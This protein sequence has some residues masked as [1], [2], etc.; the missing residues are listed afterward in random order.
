MSNAATIA[1]RNRTISIVVPAY[2]AAEFI[3]DT[4]DS[5]QR[6]TYRP[7]EIIVVDDGST[8]GTAAFVRD[9]FPDVKLI[10]QRNQGAAAARNAGIAVATGELIG[11]VDADDRWLPDAAARLEAALRQSPESVALA[12]AW[13]TFIDD[14]G[15]PIGSG[16]PSFIAGDV[17]ATL[18]AVNFLG[19]ASATLVRR[20]AFERV[21]LFD[22]SLKTQDA[23]GCDDWDLYLRIAERFQFAV[24]PEYLIEYRKM[25][26]SMTVGNPDSMS[27]S[28]A[29]VLRRM[30][31]RG[32]HMP[33]LVRRMSH[34]IFYTYLAS[35]C[36]RHGRFRESQSCLAKAVWCG[37][38]WIC[39]LPSFYICLANVLLRRKGDS[40]AASSVRT[41]DSVGANRRF[42]AVL[43]RGVHRV[44]SKAC[45]QIPR[46]TVVS[47]P[48]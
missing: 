34:A 16:L 43:L 21:G 26:G 37:M 24:V 5:L 46:Q 23:S 32:I 27:R 11:F 15:R 10:E 41:A 9:N 8:D 30:T 20:P 2:N 25:P 7:I 13:S 36:R 33:W 31:E 29:M 3:G 45:G 39:L 44:L 14:R 35:E 17:W 18:V 38:P 47:D 48:P 1:P 6:Q 22:T 19:N 42:D 40:G 12:Y 4:I 28:H